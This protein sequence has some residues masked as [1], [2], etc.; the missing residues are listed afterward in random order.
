MISSWRR[1]GVLHTPV[2]TIVRLVATEPGRMQY[3]P[4]QITRA[5]GGNT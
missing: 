5:S 2:A 3:A 1:R 4:N